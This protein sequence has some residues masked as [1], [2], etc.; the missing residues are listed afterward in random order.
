MKFK[1]TM[2]Q[3]G[4]IHFNSMKNVEITIEETETVKIARF[5]H[6]KMYSGGKCTVVATRLESGR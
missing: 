2:K 6:F 3:N 1:E 4:E 5:S